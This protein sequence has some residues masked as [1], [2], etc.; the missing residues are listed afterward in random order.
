VQRSWHAR[1]QPDPRTGLQGAGS[2]DTATEGENVSD[3]GIGSTIWVFETNHRAYTKDAI[4]S[5]TGSPIYRE[6]WQPR[7]ITGETRV[8][9]VLKSGLKVPKKR[10]SLS[11]TIDAGTHP[12]YLVSLAELDEQCWGNA[13]R[14]AISD[15]VRR[16]ATTAQLRQIA[17]IVGWREKAK[18][19]K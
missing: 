9:W 8:G 15:H 6:Y 17:E 13:D 11:W 12:P 16:H 7:E 19:A 14:F 1:P 10:S 5:S 18:S 3:I 2:G 4:G